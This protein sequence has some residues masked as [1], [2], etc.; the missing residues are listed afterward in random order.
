MASGTYPVLS[1]DFLTYS[2]IRLPIH[3]KNYKNNP[4]E[5]RKC[6]TE[7]MFL[8]FFRYTFT[9]RNLLSSTDVSAS[10]KLP[11]A[12]ILFKHKLFPIK[13]SEFLSQRYTNNKEQCV[14]KNLLCRLCL[15][16]LLSVYDD[17]SKIKNV[18]DWTEI[19]ENIF[20]AKWVLIK[21]IRWFQFS[22]KTI[23]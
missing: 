22:L 1:L 8:W 12:L 6:H 11:F 19:W 10:M 18:V 7:W 13:L 14:C 21:F 3:S 17:G 15:M 16:A 9:K 2:W 4:L 20:L 23:R 5:I